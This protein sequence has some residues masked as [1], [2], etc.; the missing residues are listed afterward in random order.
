MLLHSA[1]YHKADCFGLLL[2]TKQDKKV[3]IADA[4]P[5]F[6]QKVMSGPLEVAFD[7]VEAANDTLKI[8]GVYEAPILGAETSSIPSQMANTVL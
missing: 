1:K 6:H 5:L 4:V 3:I 2:G 8:V 7:M